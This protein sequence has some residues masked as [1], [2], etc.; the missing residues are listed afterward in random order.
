MQATLTR[1][2]PPPA[3]SPSPRLVRSRSGVE[4]NSTSPNICQRHATN[5]SKSTSRTGTISNDE[6]L[7]PS[8]SGTSRTLSSN[9]KRKSCQ[10]NRNSTRDGFIRFLQGGSK[11]RDLGSSAARPKS[12][13][14]STSPSAWA[15]SPGRSMLPPLESPVNGGGENGRSKSN[16]GK[17]SP[18]QEEEYHRFRVMQNRL[19]QWRFANARAESAMASTNTMSKDKVFHVWLRIF[20]VRKSILKKRLEIQKLKHEIKLC[21]IMNPQMSMFDKWSKLEGKN[22][23]ALSRMT[24]KLSALSVKL[25]LEDDVKGDVQSIFEAMNSAV[26]VMNEIEAMIAEFFSKAE[27]TLYLLTEFTS[28]HEHQE[29]SVRVHLLQ[30]NEESKREQCLLDWTRNKSNQPDPY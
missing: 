28:T 24:R 23:E 3:T 15:L 2:H 18:I 4:N 27:T 9:F 7:Y 21:Q 11:P 5:R 1:R 6:N 25:P 20:N 17:V 19:L 14:S 10:D 22:C 26:H 29:E 12:R 30:V 13:S 16:G 8:S